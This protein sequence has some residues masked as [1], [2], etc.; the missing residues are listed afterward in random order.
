V[1]LFKQTKRSA[2]ALYLWYQLS[3]MVL[4]AFGP[5]KFVA[6]AKAG[7]QDTKNA[8]FPFFTGMTTMRS[9]NLLVLGLSRRPAM[10]SNFFSQLH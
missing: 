4:F 9:N 5:K 8:G 6:P 2:R 10:A 1:R 3:G 7:A